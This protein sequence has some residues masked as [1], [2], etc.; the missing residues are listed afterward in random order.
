VNNGVNPAGDALEIHVDSAAATANGIT[1][2]DIK[3]QVSNYF[4]GQV[5]TT[6]LGATQD[7]GVRLWAHPPGGAKIYRS[8]VANLPLR[9]PDGH[10]FTLGTVAK[11]EF[12]GGQPELNREN[13]AQIVPVTAVI[14]GAHDLGST[15]AAVKK[16][17]DEPGLLSAGVYYDLG[18]EYKQQ[19][20]AVNGMVKVG[21]AAILAEII[22]L[23][24]LY[25]RF[26]IPIII[27]VSSLISTGAV[28]T[29]LWIT[30]VELNI[31]AMMGM[32]MI[33]GISTEMAIFLFSEYQMLEQEMPPRQAIFEAALNRLRPIVMSTLAMILALLPLGA[34]ISGSGDQMLQPLAIAIIAGSIVQLPLVLLA[35]PVLVGLLVH[36]RERVP[37]MRR[38][39]AV[40]HRLRPGAA[41]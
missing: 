9:S 36:K 7:V 10:M 25:E 31:T 41:E 29:G 37:A 39:K 12:L 32:V 24:F 13:L 33:I 5:V 35:M 38:V 15:I 17:L 1:P 28:F 30:G 19:Q 18:G 8:D 22:L 23:L 11:V 16:V 2:A 4:G 40:V 14:G 3:D 20:M 6:Y 27:I 21:T 34:A 26:S